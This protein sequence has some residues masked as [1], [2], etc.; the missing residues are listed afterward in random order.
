MH[1]AHLWFG[2]IRGR[3]YARV[4]WLGGREDIQEAPAGSW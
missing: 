4:D 3:Y 1:A 2:S